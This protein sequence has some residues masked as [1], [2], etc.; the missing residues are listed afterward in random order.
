M[1]TTGKDNLPNG[2]EGAGWRPRHDS[3]AI[4]ADDGCGVKYSC[5]F[6]RSLQVV[7]NCPLHLAVR[8][9]GQDLRLC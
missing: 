5:L 6:I 8:R 1:C 3:V 9:L 4:I 2:S 7:V